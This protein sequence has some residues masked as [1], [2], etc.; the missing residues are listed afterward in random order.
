MLPGCTWGERVLLGRDVRDDASGQ[1][2]GQQQRLRQRRCER[3]RSP[4]SQRGSSRGGPVAALLREAHAHLEDYAGIH[5]KRIEV[6][7]IVKELKPTQTGGSEGFKPYVTYEV[8]VT[9]RGAGARTNRN[10]YEAGHDVEN[11]RVS[12]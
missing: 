11:G 8:L 9:D 6:D 7:G 3:Q 1:R 10:L 2:R 5:P 12:V 4:N